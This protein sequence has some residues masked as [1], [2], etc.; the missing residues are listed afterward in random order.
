[1]TRKRKAPAEYLAAS[2]GQPLLI[3][4]AVGAAAAGG[5]AYLALRRRR[6]GG[7][8]HRPAAFRWP[9][10]R[11]NIAQT[12]DAGAEQIRD[13]DKKRDWDRVD[14]Q[15]DESFPASDPPATR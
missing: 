6:N 9:V 11:E 7:H 14:E 1:M 12:R 8:E 13:L 5:F 3:G 2:I 15:L 10:D 4:L